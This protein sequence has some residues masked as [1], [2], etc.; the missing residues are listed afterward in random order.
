[1]SDLHEFRLVP[2]PD[3]SGTGEVAVPT[4]KLG[5]PDWLYGQHRG[6]TGPCQ[7]CDGTGEVVGD[8]DEDERR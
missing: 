2:C 3:C 1:M 6:V 4:D 5:R 8:D 7:N